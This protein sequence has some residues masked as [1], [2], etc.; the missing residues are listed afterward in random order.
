MKYVQRLLFALLLVLLAYEVMCFPGFT[1]AKTGSLHM[2]YAA[3]RTLPD[4]DY[5]IA[6]SGTT[7]KSSFYYL[8]I[9]GYASSA[10]N[11]TN[12]SLAGP[13][14][15]DALPEYDIWNIK[16]SNGYYTIKQKTSNMI[17][18]VDSTNE[19]AN[20][21][22]SQN[23]YWG[24]NQVWAITA[25]GNNGYRVQAKGSSYYLEVENGQ[26]KSGANAKL[27]NT[28]S[29][30]S[31]SFWNYYSNSQSWLFIPYKPAQAVANGRYIL[32]SGM[33]SSLELD[34]VGDTGNIKNGTNIQ[35]YKDTASSR[36]NSFNF[37]KLSNGYYKIIHAASGKAME[38]SNGSV[39]YSSNVALNAFTGSIYQ[40]WAVTK[41]GNLFVIRSRCSG[42]ALEVMGKGT[43]NG[44]NVVQYPFNG[45]NLQTNQAW[46]MVPA[47]YGVNYNANGGSGAPAGQI[48]YYKEALNLTS[49]IPY[50]NGYSFTGWNTKANGSG[51]TYYAGANYNNDAAL[52]LYAQW[53]RIGN[54]S[55]K[56][57]QKVKIV[58]A[59]SRKKRK[60]EIKWKKLTGITGYVLRIS[61]NKK[62]KNDT[63][64]RRYKKSKVKI[65][66]EVWSSSTFYVKMRAYKKK[67]K[68]TYYGKWSKVKK[69]KVK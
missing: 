19:G 66:E 59:K 69:V 13:D 27:G 14:K 29:S 43:A 7:D 56:V 50:R 25:T 67:G 64:E 62:F 47:E 42:Y 30:Q 8:D 57:P 12:V 11:N 45:K 3:D 65:S 58:Y 63:G 34:V 2:V 40:Q 20:V 60:V 36:Y 18:S 22:V 5:M 1:G 26:A 28:Q 10:K 51:T 61:T 24:N 21:K 17:L 15:N 4:G 48:K 32:L 16:Y 41:S 9:E 53:E 37:V 31:Y 23:N 39:T 54:S 6:F 52:T 49:S 35:I 46:R 55:K 38:V 68:K 33:D 44:T